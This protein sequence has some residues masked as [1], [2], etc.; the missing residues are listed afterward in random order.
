MSH[1]SPASPAQP[2]EI[3]A[4]FGP[5]GSIPDVIAATKRAEDL[6]LATISF[7]DHYHALQPAWAMVCGW[8]LYGYL[9]A[10]TERIRFVPMVLCSLNYRLGV[11]AKESSMLQIASGGRFELG[12]G[13]GDF[14]KEFRAWGEPWPPVE[15]RVATLAERVRALRRI[16]TG[17]QVTIDGDYVKLTAACCT[18]VAAEP[19]RIVIGA[20]SS[21]RV[22]D[23]TLDVADDL[24]VYGEEEIV[25]YAL[26]R[27]ASAD[28]PVAVSV[29]AHRPDEPPT[30]DDLV[31]EITR[32]RALGVSRYIM[33][34]GWADTLVPEIEHLA[35]ARSLVHATI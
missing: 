34:Y 22:I 10:I 19:P 33:T 20:G 3:G 21:R 29:F 9:A 11:L 26:E 6:G 1:P 17:E 28:R 31:V 12:I 5:T 4:C 8:S 25:R 15:E 13:A 30:V 23:A 16:W 7:W 14:V 35:E 18:P 27:A 32:W 2:I 24:N